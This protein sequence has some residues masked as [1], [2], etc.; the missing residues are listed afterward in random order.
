M[1]WAL[2]KPVTGVVILMKL[3]LLTCAFAALAIATSALAQFSKD[4]KDE[5]I[6]EIDQVLSKRA[7][8]PGVDLAKWRSF[9]DQRKEKLDESDSPRQFAGVV[10][11]AF[12]EFGLSHM[13]LMPG[14][15]RGWGGEE[16]LAQ[17]RFA[18]REQGPDLQWIEDDAALIRIP[19]FESSYDPAD[20]ADLL[21][22]AKD[23]K[24]LI[25]DLRGDPGGEMGNMRQFLGLLLPP[26]S[27]IG[28]FVSRSMAS[29]FEAANGDAKD[30]VAIAKWAHHEI[31]T[32]SAG[33][34]SF[35]GKIAVLVDG[36][37]AS[38]AEIVAETLRE[39]LQTPIVGSPTAGAVLVSVFD[40]LSFGFRIQI[41][42]GDYVSHGGQRLEGHPVTPDIRADGASAVDA[43]LSRLKD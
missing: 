42:I 4:Q 38:A 21:K 24:Y 25:V 16:L 7:F 17:G 37:S 12:R 22:S 20:V 28:T 2:G 29:D 31:R 33:V 8:V 5:L 35:K 27:P 23:A 9:L 1:K 36:H 30:P 34:E 6:S 40:R 15:M 19:S 39:G 14:R 13:M 43:A 3:R 18:P 26:D 10:N 41:P 11:G 32:P